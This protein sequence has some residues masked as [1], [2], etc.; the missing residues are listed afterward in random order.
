M[1]SECS[2]QSCPVDFLLI[3]GVKDMGE[4]YFQIEEQLQ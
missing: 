4:Q 1:I 3:T 2:L